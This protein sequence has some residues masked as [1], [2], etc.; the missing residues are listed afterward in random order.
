MERG[1]LEYLKDDRN[2]VEQI[3]KQHY[4]A[5]QA[6]AERHQQLN[7]VTAD[8]KTVQAVTLQSWRCHGHQ[9]DSAQDSDTRF[10]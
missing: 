6:E 8:G 4:H 2:P 9:R 1:E 5:R 10:A 7:I 3:R